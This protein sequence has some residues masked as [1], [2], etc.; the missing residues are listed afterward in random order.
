MRIPC[1][2]AF[3]LDEYVDWRAREEGIPT[4]RLCPRG[5][6]RAFNAKSAAAAAA[7]AVAAAAASGGA[8]GDGGISAREMLSSAAGS[9]LRKGAVSK[10]GSGRGLFSTVRW[11]EKLLLLTPQSVCYFDRL[12]EDDDTNT[13]AR[14]IVLDASARV[15]LLDD[16]ERDTRGPPHQL[17][18]HTH[19]RDYVFG[20]ATAA[21][22]DA[23][24]DALEQALRA[25]PHDAVTE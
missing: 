17:R 22:A 14:L 19:A 6:G 25:P 10:R 15:A 7:A 12:D 20:V 11:K 24:V 18:L 1:G 9:V 5:G 8:A 16:A 2:S 21:E 3:D 13:I 4:S 23:W